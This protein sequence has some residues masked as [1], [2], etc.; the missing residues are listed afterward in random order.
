MN[1]S[2]ATSFTPLFT[3][4]DR[5]V[6][7]FA[8]PYATRG[9][10]DGDVE[11]APAASNKREAGEWS[12]VERQLRRGS[13][14]TSKLSPIEISKDN[15]VRFAKCRLFLS[16]YACVTEY[17]LVFVERQDHAPLAARSA[18]DRIS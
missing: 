17:L 12:G 16:I 13:F 14:Q 10:L 4:N 6:Q 1:D 2:E 11:A 15:W 5:G 9:P 7:L 8:A 18:A 3:I